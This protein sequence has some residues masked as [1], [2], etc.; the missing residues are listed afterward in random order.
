MRGL[1]RNKQATYYALYNSSTAAKDEYGNETGEIDITRANPVRIKA[2][3]SIAQGDVETE[4]FGNFTD[5][6]KVLII[7]D[8]NCP[9]NENS[10]LWIDQLDKLKPY[11]Y[12]VMRVGTSL[13]H[14]LIAV[15]KVSVSAKN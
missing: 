8:I 3:V 14:V 12:K 4:I 5:Y 13:N 1:E 10:V 11:D 2:C 9:I 15:S 7:H 6:D